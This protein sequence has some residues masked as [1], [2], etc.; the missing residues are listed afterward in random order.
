M[1]FYQLPI[2][3]QWLIAI[4][5]FLAGFY[6]LSWLD[7]LWKL[8]LIFIALP[9]LQFCCT[10][11][12]R[13][14]GIY[15]TLSPSVFT[16]LPSSKK[17]ELH[18]ITTFDYL[19]EFNWSDKGKVAQRKLL[20]NYG[21]AF[22]YL[23]EQIETQQIPPTVW[24]VGNSYFFS[25][26]TTKKLGF[27]IFPSDAITKFCSCLNAIELIGLYSFSQGKWAIPKFWQVR[28]LIISGENLCL[29]KDLILRIL[30]KLEKRPFFP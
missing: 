21:K 3:L 6:A 12:F 17:Y 4:V 30:K 1:R 14:L 28:A 13:L 25:E 29:Q 20:L 9:F 18:N 8:P 22:L 23:I 15:T 2:L 7:T 19:Q 5:L 11:L 10:P 26:R 24:I 27:Q 16:I